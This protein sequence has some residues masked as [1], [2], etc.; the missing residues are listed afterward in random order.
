MPVYPTRDTK[1]PMRAQ[2]ARILALILALIFLLV[3]ILLGVFDAPQYAARAFDS[4]GLHYLSSKLLVIGFKLPYRLGLDIQ[5]GTHLVYQA[6]LGN[7]QSS[8]YGNSMDAVR[9]VI[10]R[11]VDL[12]GVAEPVVQVEKSGEDW[13][14]IVELAG[15][16]DINSAIRLIGE[17]PYLEFREARPEEERDKI[18]EAQKNK[19]RLVEDPYFI[20]TELTGRHVKRTEVRFDQTVFQPQISLELTD[21]G[22]IIF[23]ELTKKNV[24]KQL[25]IYLDGSPISAPTVQEAISGGKAQITGNFTPESAK[26]LVGRLN[27]GAL[28]VPITLIVQQSV[29]ASLGQESL[30]RSLRAALIGFA[31]VAI[32]MIFWYRLLGV[33]AVLAL[34]LYTVLVLAIFK[35]IPVTVTVAGIAGFVL[36]VGMAVDANVLIFERLKEELRS[37]KMLQDAVLEGFGRAWTSIRD[38][39]VSSIITS[40]I[41]YWLGT[42]VVKGFALTLI[43]GILISMFSAIS[44]TRTLLFAAMSPRMQKMRVLFMSGISR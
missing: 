7:I 12:F 11:R 21:E 39:N 29:E 26:E 22:A 4:I 43:I 17:T 37:G 5:G 3:G 36:S 28:P 42:S 2:T 20:P 8:D 41:L 6:D 40:L 23:E 25:A 35:A 34:L 14:L 9:D 38:S 16:R 15:I 19:E 30:N 27:A 18:L 44:V 10:E 33:L 31:A 32:F 1:K 13:R 24:G